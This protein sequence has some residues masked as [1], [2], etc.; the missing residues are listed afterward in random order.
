VFDMIQFVNLSWAPNMFEL[1][2]ML[3]KY[4]YSN[5]PVK[6]PYKF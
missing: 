6:A 1:L 2:A 4:D 5:P 3:M